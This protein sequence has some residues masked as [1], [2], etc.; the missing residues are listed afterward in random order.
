VQL[1]EAVGL[2][3]VGLGGDEDQRVLVGPV[4]EVAVDRVMAEVGLTAGE[5]LG[6]RRVG[7]V[8]DLVKGLVPVDQLGLLAQK[9][10][11]SS[12]ERR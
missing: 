5:P 4:L 8:A 10:S 3:G 11:R 12:M 9:P 1:A 7:V 2:F 6:E